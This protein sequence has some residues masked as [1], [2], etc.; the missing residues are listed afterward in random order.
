MDTRRLIEILRATINPHQ[1]QQAE[2]QLNEV[3]KIIGFAPSLLQVVMMNDVEMPVRQAG[4][5]YLKNLITH[6]WPEPGEVEH[7]QPLPFHIHEQDRAMIRDSIVDAI[8]HAPELIRTQLAIC[9][10]QIVKYD[11]P[12]RWTAVVDKINI[13]LQNP[14]TFVWM[15]ALMALYQLVK[16]YE[17]KKPEEKGPLTEAMNLLLPLIYQGCIH[18]LPDDSEYS[19]T[20]Q[21]LILKIFFALVQY[22]LPLDLITKEVFQQ[23]MEL[24]LVIVNR[25]V[26]EHTNQVDEEER[27]DLV[28]W[29]CK[30]WALHLFAR[31]FERFGSPG[32]VSKEYRQFADYYL[33]QY[34]GGV[35]EALFK[36][37]DEYRRRVYLSPRALQLTL[38][39]INTG[40]G[41]LFS[42]KILKPHI[43]AVIQEVLFP[44]MCY[45]DQDDE[46]WHSDP[47]EYIRMKFDIF[48]DFVSPV[49]AAQTLYHTIAKKRRDVLNE[50]MAFV[51]TIFNNPMATPR[52]K[53]GALHMVGTVADVL[54]KRKLY[55]DQME[56]MLVS[57]VFPE[58]QSPHGY[59]RARACWVLHHF[60][61]IKYKNDPSLQ[62]A[63]EFTQN[64]L[65]HDKEL[66]VKVEAAI[67]LQ[68]LIVNQEKALQMIQ[69]NVQPII[70]ELLNLIRETENDDLTNVMQRL[71]C[72]FSEQVMPIAVDITRHLT[73]TFCKLLDGE[74]NS[75]EK[76]VTA[77]GLLNTIEMI[78][79]VM[80]D[81]PAI[82]AELEKVVI[83][84]IALIFNQG[85]MEFYEEALTLVYSLTTN[86]ISSDMWH[87]FEMM[88]NLLQ[89]DGIDYFTDMMPALHNFVTIDT[90]TFVRNEKYLLAMFNMSKAVLT[91]D[92]GEDPECYAA[93]L[94]E[95]ILLQ[96]KGLIDQCIPSFV[97]LVLER[98]TK[99]IKTSELRTMCMQV[100]I[101]ALQYNPQLL[102]RTLENLQMQLPI[103]N[104]SVTHSFIEQWI[105][106]TDCFLGL[107][108]RKMCVLGLCTLLTLGSDRP[109]VVSESANLILPSLIL[110]FN[111]LKRAYANKD[112]CPIDEYVVFKEILQNIHSTDINWYNQLT[113]CLT[114]D[115]QKSLNDICVLAD[116][117]KAAAES[118]RIEQSGGYV[119]QCQTIPTSFNFGG[120]LS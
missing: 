86:R 80:E 62:Q 20:L 98:L 118:K 5:I 89:K 107:H 57:R 95:V 40:V 73:S 52:Q 32:D 117:R 15:G 30:K 11:Y 97:T 102:L 68:L 85:V 1:R 115:Q 61:E 75:D 13:F 70:L 78:L 88:Y 55:K 28:W 84:V 58:F 46:L 17:Y 79:D 72:S 116:Q 66:P 93:K 42:W 47:Q 6:N 87:V 104:K 24:L 106:D 63:V 65:L 19:V 120:N 119:F 31:I 60:S 109:Q 8:V 100:I 101:A 105:Q 67:A 54:L 110:L 71:V 94:L 48:E 64:C 10:S 74:D 59:L 53:D 21:K 37:L 25:P 34:S 38:N 7:G 44:L 108:D 103:T 12:Q 26:P 114:P 83:D 50:S 77:M 23:W 111:G 90:P 2:E 45:T 29:K 16:N 35:L 69:P 82:L 4:V 91:S 27:G 9:I 112:D 51:L 81:N 96:C 49:M 99:E 39:Y 43:L 18:L 3:H 92:T 14:D 76:V 56:P 113:N 33:K 36:V 41:H 22:F